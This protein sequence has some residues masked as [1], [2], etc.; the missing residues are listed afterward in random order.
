MKKNITGDRRQKT[1]YRRLETGYRRQKAENRIQ[2]ALS[3]GYSIF[4][5]LYSIFPLSSFIPIRN[6]MLDVRCWTFI[7]SQAL[8]LLS[9]L[10]KNRALY[11]HII[12]KAKLSA[13]FYKDERPT[14]KSWSEFISSSLFRRLLKRHNISVWREASD[15][16]AQYRDVMKKQYRQGNSCIYQD[17]DED[18]SIFLKNRF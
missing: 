17:K 13:F 2:E 11:Q 18:F 5:I 10:P 1:E 14:I 8:V 9:T 15:Q 12:K 16:L 3:V 7:G 4:C 6:S